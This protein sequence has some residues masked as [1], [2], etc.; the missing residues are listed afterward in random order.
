MKLILLRHGQTEWNLASKMQG[1]RD[2]K[3]TA[4]ARKHLK[5]LAKKQI[6]CDVIY[7]S[8]LGRAMATA[9]IVA[10]QNGAR[11]IIDKRIRERNFGV[12]SGHKKNCNKVP[13]NYW[14]AYQQRYL[15]PITHV[16][17]LESELDFEQRIK[18]FIWHLAHKHQEQKV[19]VIGH[20]EWLRALVN[21]NE[22]LESW[23]QGEGVV[24]NAIPYYIKINIKLY[25]PTGD[26][27]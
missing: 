23:H 16:P 6:G 19:L 22:G 3:L 11:I 18:A 5:Q 12:L 1:W 25:C 15:Q 24:G 10:N 20:G 13:V 26:N 21:I 4:T 2:S 27:K 9:R 7:S 8:D 17:T 14:L